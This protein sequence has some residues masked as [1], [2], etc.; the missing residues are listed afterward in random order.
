LRQ[1]RPNSAS[2]LQQQQVGDQKARIGFEEE[3]YSLQR[4][5]ADM[6][7]TL[8]NRIEKYSSMFNLPN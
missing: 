4:E 1:D 8:Q 5:L 7:K 2:R 3:A 6:Q